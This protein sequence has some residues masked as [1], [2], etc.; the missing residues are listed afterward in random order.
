MSG[1]GLYFNFPF[2]SR[3]R[4]YDKAGKG[5]YFSDG[6]PA[7]PERD[8]QVFFM[9]KE[10]YQEFTCPGQNTQYF[11]CKV[12]SDKEIYPCIGKWRMGMPGM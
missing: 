2:L 11:S 12:P 1:I 3:K 10:G 6:L 9:D 4:L 7:V 8:A 5:P